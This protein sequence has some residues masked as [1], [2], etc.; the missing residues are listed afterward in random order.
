MK[1]GC[2][3]ASGAVSVK[4][5]T[6]APTNYPGGRGGAPGPRTLAWPHTLHQRLQ[7]G[8]PEEA[9]DAAPKVT[10]EHSQTEA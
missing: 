7:A 10:P 9:A 4:G 3:L 8:P 2:P 1:G 6:P 5:L